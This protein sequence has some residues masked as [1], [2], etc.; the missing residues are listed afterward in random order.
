MIRNRPRNMITLAEAK[1]Q[2]FSFKPIEHIDTTN[3]MNSLFNQVLLS[4]GTTSRMDSSII[5]LQIICL[6]G[7]AF[8]LKSFLNDFLRKEGAIATEFL[9]NSQMKAGINVSYCSPF[10]MTPIMCSILWN[11]EPELIRILYS[12]G[13][14]LESVD[15]NYNFPEER[16]QLIPYFDHVS[17][18]GIGRNPFPMWRDMN[19]FKNIIQEIRRLTNEEVSPVQWRFPEKVI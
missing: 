18:N 13:A 2:I 9:V 3:F 12:F 6:V 19:C 14:K 17:N 15:L 11:D 1:E 5:K 4:T 7:N 8:E 10:Y 16:L